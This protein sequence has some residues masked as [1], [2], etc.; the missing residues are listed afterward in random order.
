MRMTSHHVTRDDAYTAV[1]ILVQ[2]LSR[3]R[4]AKVTIHHGARRVAHSDAIKYVA[5]M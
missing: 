1:I 5:N 3:D 4:L 2:Y